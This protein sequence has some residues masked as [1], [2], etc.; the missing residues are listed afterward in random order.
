MGQ[1]IGEGH[2]T[3]MFRKGAVELG[4]YLPAFNTAGTQTIEDQGIFPNATQ[5]EI[6]TAR[7]ETGLDAEQEQ[8]QAA[9]PGTPAQAEAKPEKSILGYDLPAQDQAQTRGHEQTRTRGR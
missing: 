3:G 1:K 8:K 7:K 6:A 5:G 2:A 9:Q 4:Q